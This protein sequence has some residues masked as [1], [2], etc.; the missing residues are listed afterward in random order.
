M[1]RASA[2]LRQKSYR[3]A[4]E[5]IG[6]GGMKNMAVTRMVMS[7]EC[8]GCGESNKEIAVPELPDTPEKIAS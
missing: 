6:G 8:T 2:F 4:W 3:T 1:A 7:L 5:G